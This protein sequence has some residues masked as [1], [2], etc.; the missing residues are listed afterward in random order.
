MHFYRFAFLLVLLFSVSTQMSAQ[1][2]ILKIADTYFKNEVYQ[3]AAQYYLSAG[4]KAGDKDVRFKLAV[5]YFETNDVATSKGL[6]NKLYQDQYDKREL[7]YYLAMIAHDE[8]EF[9]RAISHYK[10]YLR[11]LPGGHKTEK[12][13]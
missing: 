12:W 8:W 3:K 4:K 9:E 5:C 2:E 10:A 13:L 1:K 6:F 7:S 11:K